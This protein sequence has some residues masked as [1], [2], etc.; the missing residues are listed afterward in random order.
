MFIHQLKSCIPWYPLLKSCDMNLLH[1]LQSPGVKTA[2]GWRQPCCDTHTHLWTFAS[3]VIAD[4]KVILAGWAEGTA[5][6]TCAAS[7]NEPSPPPLSANPPEERCAIRLQYAAT[8]PPHPPGWGSP[9]APCAPLKVLAAWLHCSKSR[10][11][12]LFPIEAHQQPHG[13]PV[14][15]CTASLQPHRT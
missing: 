14:Y 4:S 10:E 15:T 11:S 7:I 13:M 12:F 3:N 9:G 5:P 8:Y 1:W 2:Q 6:C